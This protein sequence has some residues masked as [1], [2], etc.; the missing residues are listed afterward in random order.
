M[1]W[2]I[3][4]GTTMTK[5][6]GFFQWIESGSQALDL[7]MQDIYHAINGF[8]GLEPA[9][10]SPQLMKMANEFY[11]SSKKSSEEE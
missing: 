4:S 2:T 11:E 3:R 6:N 9:A 7:E 1:R 5:N 10:L 8:G